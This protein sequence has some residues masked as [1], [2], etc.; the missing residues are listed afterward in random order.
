MV[1]AAP[2]ADKPGQLYYVIGPSGAGKDS[3]ISA[4]REQ[5]VK[6]LVVAHRYIT[7]AA[8]AGGENHVELSDD[9]FFIRYSRNMF[10]MSWQAH[11][12]S[13]GIG[14]E[15]HQWMDAGL[16]VVVNGSRAYLDAARDLFGERLVP[17]VVSV[18][19]KVLEARLRARGR[20]SEAEITL[21]LQR[22]ADYCVDSESTLNNTLCIDNSGTID[23]SIAQFARLKEQAER[24][25]E[26]AGG[27]A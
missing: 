4:L 13:Y 24:L 2:K 9:E 14:Q 11:G 23:Q 1:N 8:D 3:I 19:P 5:F 10:A 18:K 26:P 15:V 17:V 20:E 16:S 25:A 12:M 21:R 7:R 6:D 22:A 27:V